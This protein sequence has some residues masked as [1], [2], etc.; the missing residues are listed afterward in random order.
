MLL[1]LGNLKYNGRKYV[2]GDI[3]DAELTDREVTS[4]V[5]AGAIKVVGEKREEV[6]VKDK[7]PTQMK[8][9]EQKT[10]AELAAMKPNPNWAKSRLLGLAKARGVEAD[11]AMTREEIYN[12]LTGET[13]PEKSEEDETDGAEDNKEEG[14]TEEKKEELETK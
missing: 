7:T 1:V 8:A 13:L 2:D 10:Q 12:L 9:D 14:K 3:L 4:L 5:D 11:E 6:R